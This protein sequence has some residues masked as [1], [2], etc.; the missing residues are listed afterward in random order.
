MNFLRSELDIMVQWM[1]ERDAIRVRKEQGQ[2]KPWTKDPLLSNYRW[3]NVRRMDDRVSVAMLAH[4]YAPNGRAEVDL[5]AAVLGRLVNWP[6]S[7]M[8]ITDGAPFQLDH[9]K[10]A[11]ERLAARAESGAKVFTG[12]YVVPGVPGFSKVD[13][14]CNLVDLV[15]SR[16]GSFLGDSMAETW[17]KLIQVD[18][19]GS[20]LA[21]QMVADMVHLK[22]GQ[23]WT[24]PMTWAPIGPGSAR[25]LN[26]L[27]GRPKDQAVS[28][29]EFERALPAL[30]AVLRPMVP[31]LCADRGLQAMDFQNCLCEFDKTRRL[32]LVEGKVRARYDGAG[33]SQT[34]LI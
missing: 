16:S 27:L 2:P 24:D 9:L 14:V 32:M 22:A 18:G 11:R 8:T 15:A 7:L 25:G 5:V 6:D 30:M 12:A 1:T 28:Q 19:I 23:G 3:C 26:R 17:S 20:F 4:W 13:S 29:A 34:S 21:G 33:D 10:V 31:E